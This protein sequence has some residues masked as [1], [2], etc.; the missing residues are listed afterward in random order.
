VDEVLAVGDA[1]FQQKCFEK[2]EQVAKSGR[3]V[4]LV[5]HQL[6]VVRRLCQHAIYLKDGQLNLLGGCEY[7]LDRYLA[8]STSTPLPGSW[9]SFPQRAYPFAPGQPT[10]QAQFRA[11]RYSG[12]NGDHVRPNQPLVVNV[13]VESSIPQTATYFS[14]VLSDLYGTK[15]V[16]AHI[17]NRGLSLPL[18]AGL[19]T[20]TVRIPSL[21]LNAGTYRVGLYLASSED[22]FDRLVDA[23]QIEVVGSGEDDRYGGTMWGDGVVTCDAELECDG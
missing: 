13:Q 23:F 10:G 3:T 7:V 16:A 12:D 15:L 21:H 18:N 22:L 8:E 14:V 5:S 6:A 19:N 2:M 11:A 9:T 20:V 17:H 1:D 4:F